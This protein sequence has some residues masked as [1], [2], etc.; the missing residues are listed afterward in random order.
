MSDFQLLANQPVWTIG[1]DFE[2]Q[3]RNEGF[4]YIAGVD[5]V[6]RGCLAGPVVAAA[7]ILD[8]SKP[9]PKGLNDS[10]KLTALQRESIAEELKEIILAY[11]IG[12]IDA[13]EIDRINILEATKKS[14]CLAISYLKP[15]ADYLLIDAL[16]LKQIF[17]PQKAIIKGDAISASIAAASILAKTYRDNLM[18]EY[19]NVYPQYG[20]A[21]HVGYGTKEHFN[22][23]RMHG[24]CPLHRKTFRGVV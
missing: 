8:S 7:C 3:A 23:L 4:R 2:D 6:G 16:Q 20:F 13:E 17:I 1:V 5:E 21:S 19:D 22:A 18:H 24:H 15:Q 14:M 10:K 9:L 11:S 12:Q